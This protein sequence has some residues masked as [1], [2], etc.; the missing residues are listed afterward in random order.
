MKIDFVFPFVDASDPEWRKQY[1]TFF[2]KSFESTRFKDLGILEF[3]FRCLEVNAPWINKVYLLVSSESQVPK[4]V[5]KSQV[6]IITHEQFI[7]KEYLPCFNSCT[8]EMF[9][10]NIPDLEEHFIYGNDDMFLNCKTM[11]T[12]FFSESGTPRGLYSDKYSASGKWQEHCKRI[13][14]V[15]SKTKDYYIMPP[16]FYTSQLKSS[17]KKVYEKYKNEIENSITPKRKLNQNLNQY[18]YLY[19]NIVNQNFEQTNGIDFVY[20][21]TSNS[22]QDIVRDI[23]QNKSICINDGLDFVP[24]NFNLVVAAFKAKYPTKSKYEIGI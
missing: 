6:K 16:H 3:L 23:S 2:P 7:P 12:D 17:C 11:P 15:V 1:D 19:Y 9:L 24:E 5:D 4:W 18:L 13:Y 21:S 20:H 14:S 22:M 10:H 8:I